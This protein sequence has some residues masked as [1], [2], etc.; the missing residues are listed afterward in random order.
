MDAPQYFDLIG[1]AADLMSDVSSGT[2]GSGGA[3][4]VQAKM[5]NKSFHC[6]V[7]S[8]QITIYASNINSYDITNAAPIATVA[9]T[10]TIIDHQSAAMFYF[11]D[12]NSNAN[13]GI[14][15]RMST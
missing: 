1:S 13:G 10:S 3:S 6:I 12:I 5:L 15:C 9:N 8:G 11:T 14:E 2:V 7:N 4:L